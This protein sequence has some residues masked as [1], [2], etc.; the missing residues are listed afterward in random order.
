MLTVNSLTY[1][2]PGNWL[3]TGKEVIRDV[4]FE[5]RPG[6]FFGF[7]GHNG[8][9]KTTTFKCLLGLIPPTSGEISI[10]GVPNGLPESRRSLGYVPEHPYFY[11][12]LT[13]GEAVV[14]FARLAGLSRYD[15]ES[16]T[17]RA[18]ERL[19]I[20]NR[21][22]DQLRTLSKGLLQRMAMAQAI[23]AEP[24][25]LILDE[26]FSG[27]DPLG[28]RDFREL[29]EEQRKK[30]VSVIIASHI[31]AD[32]EQ[33]CDR[34]TI[35]VKGVS[36]GTF[37]LRNLPALRTARFEIELCGPKQQIDILAQRAAEVREI[38]GNTILCFA[39]RDSSE[40]AL[41]AALN[42]DIE[43]LSYGCSKGTLDDLFTHL[44]HTSGNDSSSF[45]SHE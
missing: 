34:A 27:L 37:D 19:G 36:R 28:R 26:P 45:K 4:S 24:A 9:G 6:E 29:L 14:M 18:L 21:Y 42:Q 33:I 22:G 30:G 44:V 3:R 12:H 25:L 17:R 13:V 35:L 16:S 7:L 11:D 5:V 43:V 8:A 23:V 38:H 41:R 31:L 10:A 15:S 2:Y 1:R 20:A 39:S 32:V 40:S